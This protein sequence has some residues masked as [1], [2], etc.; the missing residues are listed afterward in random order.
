MIPRG[1]RA[2]FLGVR[3]SAWLQSTPSEEVRMATLEEPLDRE[4]RDED[5]EAWDAEEPHRRNWW[6]LVSVVLALAVIFV[7]YQWN[8]AAG[9]EKALAAQVQALRA[10]GEGLRLQAEEA[11][12]AVEAMEKRVAALA[13]EK[14]ALADRVAA[15]EKDRAAL[16]R[17]AE[18]E[19][20]RPARE[21]ARPRTPPLKRR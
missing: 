3:R 17:E 18:R 16:A 7:G 1:R 20:A 10:E 9:R 6:G 14:A 2:D 19:R 11:R 15:L 4:G 8:Q 12:R 5:A 21:P 13:A